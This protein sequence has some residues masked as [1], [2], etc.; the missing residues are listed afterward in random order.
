MSRLCADGDIGGWW[1][2]DFGKLIAEMG[3]VSTGI[4]Q[5]GSKHVIL[6]RRLWC[7]HVTKEVIFFK[8]AGQ[9][10]DRGIGPFGDGEGLER[11]SLSCDVKFLGESGF[12]KRNEVKVCL[13][14]IHGLGVRLD[15]RQREIGFHYTENKD[16]E[17]GTL[18]FE[19]FGRVTY[20]I[21]G[22]PMRVEELV[23]IKIVCCKLSTKANKPGFESGFIFQDVKRFD[24]WGSF[25]PKFVLDLV[26]GFG[27]GH[28]R[29]RGSWVTRYNGGSGNRVS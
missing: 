25:S 15:T 9:E 8:P 1:K 23:N 13:S 27:R 11:L 26:F 17:E 4:E 20:E 14:A 19:K 29:S 6:H 7:S 21:R 22:I 18:P 10:F 16:P 2:W 12:T 5:E 3:I 24:V 28:R